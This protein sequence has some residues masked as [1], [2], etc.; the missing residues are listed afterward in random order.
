MIHKHTIES[1]APNAP[2]AAGS[3]AIAGSLPIADSLPTAE[4]LVFRPLCVDDVDAWLELIKRIAAFEKAPSYTQHSVLLASFSDTVNPVRDNSIVG[5]DGHGE[6]RAFGRVLKN[7]AGEKAYV[8]GGVDP[9]WQRRG[10]GTA[11]LAWQESVVAA[12]FLADGQFPVKARNYVE[13]DNPALQALLAGTGYSVVRYYSEMLRAL[14]QLPAV[15]TPVG[16]SIVPLTPQLSEAVRVA[17]NDAFVDHWGSEPRSPEQWEIFMS[18]EHLRTELSAVAIDSLNGAVA[19]YQL[20]S[21]DPGKQAQNGRREGYTELLGVPR[22]WR[23]RGIAP[24]LLSDAMARFAAAGLD[25]ASL[26]VDTEN[27]TGASRL[28]KDMGYSP[29]RQSMAWEKLL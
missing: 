24:A 10:V 15:P 3:L 9:L 18:H 1:P 11:V 20:A 4:G 13:E 22:R 27:P 28:Y 14:E 16:I 5:I 26:D 7:R 19:G 6:L 23:G 12:R 21:V 8:L 25:H 17:H 29:Q 2:A